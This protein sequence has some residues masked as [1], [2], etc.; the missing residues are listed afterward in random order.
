[1]NIHFLIS[2][3]I[4]LRI[5]S[6]VY[7]K[8]ITEGLQAKGYKVIIHQLSNDF[9]FPSD[10]NSQKCKQ[11]LK[12]IN[13]SETIVIE[14][15]IFGVI[16]DILKD[17]QNP[18]IALVHVTFSA[19]QDLTA[20]QREMLLDL[21]KKAQSFALKFIAANTYATK[22]LINDGVE[23]HKVTTII[24]G[25]DHF[26]RKKNYP[27][28]PSKLLSV[29]NYCRNNGYVNL[30]KALTAL[31]GKRWELHCFGNLDIDK[32]YVE[33]LQVLIRRN[34]LKDKIWLHPTL[35][36]NALSETY[37]NADLFIHPLNFEAYSIELVTALA[38]GIPVVASTEGSNSEIIPPKM[39][40]FFKPNVIYV[41]QTIIDELLENS[42]LYNDLAS[43]VASYHKQAHSW[44]ASIDQFEQVLNTVKNS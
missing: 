24:P 36:D 27:E 22:A 25:I 10:I 18:I 33:E 28:R 41:L 39:G 8:R 5:Q 16:P 7:H 14:N 38:H 15:S 40:K 30:I 3:D 9:P 34:G 19:D 20:Y 11:I 6:H 17:I 31:K 23:A 43:E 4:N 21:A 35:S 12:S 1:M 26:A 13:P 37:L 29:A 32:G 2:G 44:E 42:V